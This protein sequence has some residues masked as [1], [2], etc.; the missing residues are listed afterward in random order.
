MVVNKKR[1]TV[2]IP[3]AMYKELM[4]R[5]AIEESKIDAEITLSAMFVRVCRAFLKNH[6]KD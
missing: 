5:K 4:D 3:N 6:P 1:V 2:Y